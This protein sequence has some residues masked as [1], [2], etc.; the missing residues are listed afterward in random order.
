MQVSL[1]LGDMANEAQWQ[2]T[3][4]SDARSDHFGSRNDLLDCKPWYGR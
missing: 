3:D 2:G 1:K 4:L